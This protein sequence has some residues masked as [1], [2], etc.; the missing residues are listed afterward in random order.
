MLIQHF[1]DSAG[2]GALF[3]NQTLRQAQGPVSIFTLRSLH[4][5]RLSDQRLWE[6]KSKFLN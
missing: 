3:K 6:H 1:A 5:D 2:S 4:F